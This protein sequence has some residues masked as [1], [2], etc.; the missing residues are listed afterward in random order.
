MSADAPD[1]APR[2]TRRPAAPW[3]VWLL[4][5]VGVVSIVGFLGL[6]LLV[7]RFDR[8]FQPARVAAAG[9][10][11]A[12][13]SVFA[14]GTPEEVKGTRFLSVDVSAS[15][16]GGS[17]GYSGPRDDRRNLLLIDEASGDSRRILPD[18]SRRI[19]ETRFLPASAGHGDPGS[20]DAALLG[21]TSTDDAPAAYY[22][23]EVAQ[24]EHPDLSDVL[25]GTLATGRQRVV[26][27]GLD[28]VDSVWMQS[29][30]RIGL[31]VRERLNLYYRIVDIPSLQVVQ[32]RPIKID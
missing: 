18:N 28:G 7:N 30:T 2:E 15:G 12:Q 14:V 13:K 3:F 19:L 24:A 31:I 17:S 16:G 26:M 23:L 1:P 6:L 32:S 27:Q 4:A 29:P 25:V 5:A 20:N 8:P 21:Q 22:L 11:G 9:G 10:G